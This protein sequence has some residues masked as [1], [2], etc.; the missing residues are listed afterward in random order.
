MKYNLSPLTSE[1][2]AVLPIL[3]TI[4]R[5]G[6]PVSRSRISL[7][8]S[9]MQAELDELNLKIYNEYWGDSPVSSLSDIPSG[10]G[11]VPLWFQAP[12]ICPIHRI[13]PFEPL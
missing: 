13:E 6:M 7:L 12:S 9:E 3:E 11:F 2:M 10:K 1:G 4:Q 5:N 8:H